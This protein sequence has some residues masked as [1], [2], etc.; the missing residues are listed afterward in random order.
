VCLVLSWGGQFVYCCM[1]SGEGTCSGH[2]GEAGGGT[3]SEDELVQI[4]GV[5]HVGRGVVAGPGEGRAGLSG[6]ALF[7]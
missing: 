1:F 2:F 4:E 3:A 5:I 6:S 7:L